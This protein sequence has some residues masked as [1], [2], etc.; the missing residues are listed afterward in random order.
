MYLDPDIFK[1]WVQTT[2]ST[3]CPP[4][5]KVLWFIQRKVS[6]ELTKISLHK[7]AKLISM[8]HEINDF[9]SSCFIF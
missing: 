1:S 7:F 8:S 2:P 6:K 4:Q 9:K 5:V 3:L